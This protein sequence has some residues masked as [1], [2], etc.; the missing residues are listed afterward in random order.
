MN[1]IFNDLLVQNLQLCSIKE[2]MRG[3]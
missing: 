1:Y 2:A 3:S